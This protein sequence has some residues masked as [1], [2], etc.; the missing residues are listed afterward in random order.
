MFWVFFPTCLFF[1]LFHI[2]W[3]IEFF[4]SDLEVSGL[5]V[6]LEKIK[7]LIN[8]EGKRKRKYMITFFLFDREG[9]PVV[10]NAQKQASSRDLDC[11][12]I[13]VPCVISSQHLI[14][15]SLLAHLP[16]LCLAF[17][18][19]CLIFLPVEAVSSLGRAPANLETARAR[20][21]SACPAIPLRLGRR[22]GSEWFRSEVG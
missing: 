18:P 15:L 2:G 12:P 13:L 10:P 14:S 6:A 21:Q 1:W 9:S 22:D 19:H 17:L 8:I 7:C 3:N 4:P 16:L 20:Q 5:T 11:L